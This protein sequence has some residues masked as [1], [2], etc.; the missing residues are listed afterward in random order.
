MTISRL[1]HA[2]DEC[3]RH[4]T[5]TVFVSTDN[6]VS[7]LARACRFRHRNGTR[8]KSLQAVSRHERDVGAGRNGKDCQL[9]GILK[10]E[11][12]AR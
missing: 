7:P 9:N 5:N 6:S 8:V 12:G 1:S 10:G 2:V 3:L 4:C 11:G